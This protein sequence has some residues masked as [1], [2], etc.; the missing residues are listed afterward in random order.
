MSHIYKLTLFFVVV[1]ICV[2]SFF[3][4]PPAAN[5][6]S[7]GNIEYDCSYDSCDATC[8][9]ACI[10]RSD[11]DDD[12]VPELMTIELDCAAARPRCQCDY[13][14]DA[15]TDNPWVELQPQCRTG[16]NAQSMPPYVSCPFGSSFECCD[17]ADSCSDTAPAC[18]G[19]GSKGSCDSAGGG[20]LCCWSSSN[21]ACVSVFDIAASN[22]CDGNPGDTGPGAVDFKL[23]E[24]IPDH[25]QSYNGK[26]AKRNCEICIDDYEGIWTAIGCIECAAHRD[27][28]N[29]NC[30]NKSAS[31][32]IERLLRVGLTMAGGFALISILG[33]GL[34]FSISQGD[35]K[36]TN[37]AKELI[38]AAVI[39]LLFIIFSVT[40][41]QFIGVNILRIPGFAS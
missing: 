10:A 16:A 1:F 25:V 18:A 20:G 4:A 14:D 26:S 21:T 40:I 22:S 38:T 2:V 12:C 41:L 15:A 39:G 17:T 28:G 37:E 7:C 8:Y 6:Q 27:G 32:I 3:H 23:C 29:P 31:S 9:S 35:P 19:F 11:P 36:R 30:E 5:A 24:Q 13:D 33:A 34:M